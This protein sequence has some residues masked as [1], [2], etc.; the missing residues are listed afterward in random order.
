MAK[1]ERITHN[2][3][4]HIFAQGKSSKTI[5]YST[6]EKMRIEGKYLYYGSTKIAYIHSNRRKI[7]I[8]L[9]EFNNRSAY[10]N[11]FNEYDLRRAFSKDWLVLKTDSFTYINNNNLSDAD[12][13]KIGINN[14][15]E[16][17]VS[18]TVG[19]YDLVDES[20]RAAYG[21]YK[22]NHDIYV[23]DVDNFHEHMTIRDREFKRSFDKYFSYYVSK[24][25][26]SEHRTC[27]VKSSPYKLYHEGLFTDDEKYKIDRAKWIHKYIYGTHLGSN[28]KQWKYDAYANEATRKEIEV[29]HDEHIRVKEAFTRKEARE[30]EERNK[31]NDLET[32]QNWLN[33]GSGS[34]LYLIPVHLRIKGDVVETTKYATVPISHAERLFK[35]FNKIVAKGERWVATDKRIPI[36]HYTCTLIDKDSDD[37]WYLVAGCHTI[38]KKEIDKFINDNKLNW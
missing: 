10:G 13:Y 34:H 26:S 7:A 3:L 35:I 6:T 29:K 11:G 28:S 33:G 5:R 25:W 22:M 8:T 14:I 19:L 18:A 38:Y 12:V 16:E 15:V 37:N 4:I 20:R 36:G 30:R 9:K 24:G 1:K 31:A 32:L 2:A 27:K 21:D 23:N 17:Y